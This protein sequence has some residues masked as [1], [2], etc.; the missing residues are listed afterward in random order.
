L[1]RLSDDDYE[2]S[3]LFMQQKKLTE[4]QQKLDEAKKG[5]EWGPSV[6][7][8]PTIPR[9]EVDRSMII[10]D[11]VAHDVSSFEHPAGQDFLK[12]YLGRDATKAFNGK[13]YNHSYYARQVLATMRK[14]RVASNDDDV[15]AEQCAVVGQGV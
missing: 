9:D 15:S 10:I 14:Y 11:G 13:V 8:L 3:R 6:E 1:I 7:D 2:R 5:F 12:P 4:A